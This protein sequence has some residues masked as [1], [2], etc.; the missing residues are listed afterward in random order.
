M[1]QAYFSANQLQQWLKRIHTEKNREQQGEL[2]SNL[3]NHLSNIFSYWCNIPLPELL[4]KIIELLSPCIQDNLFAAIM[5]TESLSYLH[6]FPFTSRPAY[7]KKILASRK[8]DQLP[9]FYRSFEIVMDQGFIVLPTPQFFLFTFMAES[10]KIRE[11]EW[12]E[13]TSFLESLYTDPFLILF[14]QYLQYLDNDLLSFLCILGEEYLLKDIANK[15]APAPHRHNCEMTLLLVYMLQRPT[16]LLSPNYRMV[17]INPESLL[18]NLQESLYHYLKNLSLY[19]QEGYNSYCCFIV[20]IW[21]QY[22]TPWKSSAILDS[23]LNSDILPAVSPCKPEKRLS[24]AESVWEDYINLNI[25][26]YTELF[27][28]MLRILCSEIL[29]KPGDIDLLLRLSEVYTLDSE[30]LL[31]FGHTN[32]RSL[33]GQ[34]KSGPISPQLDKLLMRFGVNRS[35]LYPFHDST[36]RTTAETLI[37]KAGSMGFREASELK[38]NWSGLLGVRDVAIATSSKEQLRTRP[39]FSRSLLNPWD[40][41]LRSDEFWVLYIL[42][43][44]LAW[45]IDKFVKKEDS[46]P[47]QRNLRFFASLS[48][49]LFIFLVVFS[50]SYLLF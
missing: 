26:F 5:R 16:H 36:V 35:V 13:N 50:L 9:E 17:S 33:H 48:N 2:C 10:A 14:S 42:A 6:P 1:D 7:I 27:A 34:S 41:P 32:L 39:N 22:L 46:W 37:F 21:L 28:Y 3:S 49:V 25:L 15:L 29:F 23:Y 11:C 4:Y 20:E 12:F 30:G 47:P 31:F 8:L 18:L 24:G 44:Y 40:K 38:R 45:G 19:W 43:K